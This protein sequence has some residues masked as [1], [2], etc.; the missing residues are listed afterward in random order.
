MVDE[1]GT[2]VQTEFREVKVCERWPLRIPAKRAE[3]GELWDWWEWPRMASMRANLSTGD[4]LWD[5]GTE[6]GD[7]SAIWARWVSGVAGDELVIRNGLGHPVQSWL[8]NE[9]TGGIVLVEA[10][11]MV[12]GNVRAI[13]DENEIPEPLGWH[14]GFV[15]SETAE[16]TGTGDQKREASL[17]GT[18]HPDGWPACARGPMI[19]DHGTRHLAYERDRTPTITL[20]DLVERKGL[21]VDAITMDVEG[22]ENEVLAGAKRVLAE[23]RPLVWISIHPE[24]LRDLYGL[25]RRDV[26]ARLEHSSYRWCHLAAEHE[27]HTFA[28]PEERAGDVVVPYGVSF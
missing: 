1:F 19:G 10:N 13:W 27:L 12:W 21:R 9:R 16:P 20:D 23:Q 28:Y 2:S 6:Q 7:Q 17:A 15:G 26:L 3:R 11:P 4:V 22:S 24:Q 25:T 8:E 14:V 18:P 5:L